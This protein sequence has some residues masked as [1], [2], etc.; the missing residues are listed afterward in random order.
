MPTDVVVIAVPLETY[1]QVYFPP[2]ICL[3]I[4]G[5]TFRILY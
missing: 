5:Y 2:H 1:A 4:E 3:Y